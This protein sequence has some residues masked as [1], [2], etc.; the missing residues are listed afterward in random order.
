MGDGLLP[1]MAAG[2]SPGSVIAGYR[3][4]E[5]IGRG[6]MAVVFRARDER[7]NRQVALK[8][9]SPAL[10]ADRGFRHRF[11]RESQAAAAV[12][13]PNII[14]VFEAGE[15][16]GVLFIAMRLVR[17][18]DIKSLVA[19]QG[20]LPPARVEWIVSA[21]AS[22]LDAAHGHGLVHRDVKPHNMLLEVRPGRPDHVYLSDFG[23]SKASVGSS[24]LTGSGQFLGTIDYC[25]PEQIQGQAVDGRA[26]QYALGCTA[27]ELLGGDPPFARDHGVAALYAHISAEPPKLT[28]RRSELAPAVDLVFAKVLA[29]DPTDRYTT[30]QEF[31]EALRQALGVR[32]YPFHGQESPSR[33]PSADRE[34]PESAPESGED[35]QPSAEEAGEPATPEKPKR[36][37]RVPRRRGLAAADVLVPTLPDLADSPASPLADAATESAAFPA[38]VPQ[39]VGAAVAR[40]D[41]GEHEVTAPDAVAVLTSDATDAISL[42]APP[43]ISLPTGGLHPSHPSHPSQLG[44]TTNLR[45][46]RPAPTRPQDIGEQETEVRGGSPGEPG[47]APDL[48]R[49]GRRRNT[50]LVAGAGLVVAAA[51]AVGLILSNGPSAKL[52][53]RA[54]FEAF[55]PQHFAKGVLAIRHWT[56]NGHAGSELTDTVTITNPTG[57]AQLVTYD[58]PIPAAIT[59]SLTAVRFTPAAQLADAGRVGQWKLRV[60]AHGHVVVGYKVT[61]PPDGVSKARLARWASAL[62]ALAAHLKAKPGPHHAT[63]RVRSLTVAPHHL[64]LAVGATGRLKVSGL[65][66]GN[67]NATAADLSA[68]TWRSGDSAVATVNRFGKV[69]AISAG[70]TRVTASIGS[71]SAFAQVTVTSLATPTPGTTYNSSTYT[72]PTS[73]TSPATTTTNPTPTVTPTTLAAQ[74]PASQSRAGR[75]RFGSSVN[76]LKI[77]AP[78]R[79]PQPHSGPNRPSRSRA[80]QGLVSFRAGGWYRLVMR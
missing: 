31:A 64:R 13:D 24:G 65:I 49:P 4:E 41:V 50:A 80:P 8:I 10:A 18:G 67:K 51:A 73:P 19:G 48:R 23:L 28:A 75:D 34:E 38:A 37:K 61:V 20:P 40:T 2:F 68:V 77:S 47:Q 26:D 39:E 3:L 43:E 56:L 62:G 59:P 7:L 76:V 46:I 45:T 66:A 69:S 29:K 25:A 22:A 30:C 14:P 54:A 74:P 63:S 78:G 27:F 70:T 60:P 5:Q 36:A 21:V 12:D 1:W 55:P 53:P 58:E 72:P 11:L 42:T 6:G 52:P 32:Q 16:D 15:A 35:R 71:V 44:Q 33:A 17:G 79:P 9:L 57:T